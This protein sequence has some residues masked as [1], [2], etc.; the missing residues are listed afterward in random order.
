LQKYLTCN[1]VNQS[2]YATVHNLLQKTIISTVQVEENDKAEEK[3]FLDS[4]AVHVNES[5]DLVQVKSYF[6]YLKEISNNVQGPFK[7]ALR[8]VEE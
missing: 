5:L 3:S 8:L 4:H 6:T 7:I 1:H 2:H